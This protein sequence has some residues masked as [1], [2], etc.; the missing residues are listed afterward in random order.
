MSDYKKEHEKEREEKLKKKNIKIILLGESGVGKTSLIKAYLDQKIDPNQS[1]SNAVP[2]INDMNIISTEYKSFII[3]LWDTVGQ[4]KYRSLT[5][6]FYKGS[7]IVIFVYS[8]VNKD[9]F[10]KLKEYWIQSVIEKIGK[11]IIIGIIANKADLFIKQQVKYEE[12]EKYA[13]EIK[14]EFIQTSAKNNK[15][16]LILFIN[17]LIEKLLHKENLFEKGEK[18]FLEKKEKSKKKCCF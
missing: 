1:P 12:G 5:S 6:N 11:D 2:V 13:K 14:V 17:E 4:E 18:I 16:D 7:H 15:N 10:E 3:S 8:I 9:S